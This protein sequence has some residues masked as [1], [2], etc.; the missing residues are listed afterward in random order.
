MHA[1]I[2]AGIREGGRSGLTAIAISFYFFLAMFFT[3]ILSS[4]PPYATGPALILVGALMIENLLDVQWKN[5]L[6]VREREH[7]RG[8]NM[9]GPRATCMDARVASML[10]LSC[11]CAGRL[12]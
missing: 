4:I 9:H 7:A 5:P 3:P 10:N 8:G 2:H 11:L 6:D 12:A 1:C